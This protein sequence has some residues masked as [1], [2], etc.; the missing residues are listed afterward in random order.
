VKT[1]Y[2]GVRVRPRL[3]DYKM[4]RKYLIRD[5]V[6]SLRTKGVT[7]LTFGQSLSYEVLANRLRQDKTYNKGLVR[8][9]QNFEETALIKSIDSLIS[10]PSLE[11]SLS[12]EMKELFDQ[13]HKINNLNFIYDAIMFLDDRRQSLDDINN[14]LGEKVINLSKELPSGRKEYASLI[15]GIRK[16]IADRYNIIFG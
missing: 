10:N 6:I 5:N 9:F 16:D 14:F 13:K 7:P 15:N 8:R 2:I 4:E 11:Y 3:T 1:K 12:D